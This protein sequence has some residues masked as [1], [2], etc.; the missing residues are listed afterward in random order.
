MSGNAEFVSF[1]LEGQLYGLDIRVVKEIDPN[2][3]IVPV[4]LAPSHVRG[5]VNIR[6]QVVLVMDIAKIFG[7]PPRPI[8]EESQIIILKT[9]PEIRNLRA[10]GAEVDIA[11]FGEKPIGFLVDRI[12]DVVRV[13][14]RALKPA[15]PHLSEEN[16]RF[17]MG[18]ANPDEE[19]QIILNAGDL[20]LGDSIVAGA[21]QG[22]R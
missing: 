14:A 21:R 17:V 7:G 22:G 1:W 2:V 20:I 4:P 9:A 13:P 8:T 3:D 19:F 5:L 10:L 15:P 16:A 6:G 11:P 18:V 12:G